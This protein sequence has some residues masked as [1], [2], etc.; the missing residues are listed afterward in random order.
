VG[1]FPSPRCNHVSF[2]MKEHLFVHGGVP[3]SSQQKMGN[4]YCL[5][6][7]PYLGHAGSVEL[8]LKGY[9]YLCFDF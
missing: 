4:F 7:V 5:S 2:I 6:L 3:S 9:D 1:N 8:C